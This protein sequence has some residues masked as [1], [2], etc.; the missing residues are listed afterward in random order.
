MVESV[1][2]R[3]RHGRQRLS[4]N[5]WRNF[6]AYR[7][8]QSSEQRRISRLAIAQ[9]SEIRQAAVMS[10]DAAGGPQSVLLYTFHYEA[11]RLTVVSA[12]VQCGNYD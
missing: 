8:S 9:I 11:A 7:L 1:P 12:G 2:L 4:N 3:R 5:V 10:G 6:L